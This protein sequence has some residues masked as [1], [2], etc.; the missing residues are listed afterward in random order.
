MLRQFTFIITL[1]EEDK[2][3]KIT[4][5]ILNTQRLLSCCDANV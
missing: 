2:F 3:V 5:Q 4:N 1:L